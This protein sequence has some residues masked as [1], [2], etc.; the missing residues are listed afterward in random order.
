MKRILIAHQSTIPHYRVP[1][2]NSLEQQRP[3]AWSF[4][5]VFDP[6]EVTRKRFYAEPVYSTDFK[7]PILP[8]KTIMLN[9]GGKKVCYQTFLR[10][11]AE[12][13][14]LVL[15]NAVN[16]LTYP[17]S[18]LYKFTGKRDVYRGHGKNRSFQKLNLRPRLAESL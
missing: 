5:V 15:E 9:S 18:H 1:F 4:D 14:L 6:S 11:A 12:Y 16:N 8:V 17:L 7:F 2:Y 3:S 13:D 10:A